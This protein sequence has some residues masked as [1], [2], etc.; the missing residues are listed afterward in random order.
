MNDA[1]IERLK[2]WLGFTLSGGMHYK[3]E[4]SRD[5]LE[6]CLRAIQT[7]QARSQSS[8]PAWIACS[9]R[10][11]EYGV[12]VLITLGADHDDITTASFSR[13]SSVSPY[14]WYAWRGDGKWTKD[15]VKYW[16]PIDHLRALLPEAK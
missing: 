2:T 10:M 14:M 15:K 4:V 12:D 7:L 3:H 11:P 16:M 1:D 5:A 6:E 9:E 13:D 8:A